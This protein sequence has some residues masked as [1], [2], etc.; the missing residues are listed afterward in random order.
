MLLKIFN[1]KF[2]LKNISVKF[3]RNACNSNR[4]QSD[5]QGV[6]MYSYH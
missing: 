1:T 5:E 6:A 3:H 2:Q 4:R